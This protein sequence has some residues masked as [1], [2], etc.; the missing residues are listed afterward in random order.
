MGKKTR[1]KLAEDDYNLRLKNEEY[2]KE[3]KEYK[4]SKE[5]KE[6]DVKEIDFNDLD[7]TLFDIIDD[8][9][10]MDSRLECVNVSDILYRPIYYI[11]SCYAPV[12]DSEIIIELVDILFNEIQKFLKKCKIDNKIDNNNDEIYF[13][14]NCTE[15]NMYYRISH[16]IN[17]W[18]IGQIDI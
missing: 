10:H 1:E 12:K 8:Y 15:Q 6:C 13:Y 11:P 3:Y 2:D 4:E 17:K 16:T 7:D 9:K 18:Y 5:F 14:S